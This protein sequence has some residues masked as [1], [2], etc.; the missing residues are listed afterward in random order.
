MAQ[1]SSIWGMNMLGDSPG[2]VGSDD[3]R[4]NG[5][6][7]PLARG[8]R[9]NA[10]FHLA[11]LEYGAL[12]R[13]RGELRAA[14]HLNKAQDLGADL[15][16]LGVHGDVARQGVEVINDRLIKLDE[17]IERV[18]RTLFQLHSDVGSEDKLRMERRWPI[19]QPRFEKHELQT[20][21]RLV[22]EG[23][24]SKELANLYRYELQYNFNAPRK[25]QF[26]RDELYGHASANAIESYIKFHMSLDRRVALDNLFAHRG[27]SIRRL[28]REARES[29]YTYS[30]IVNS[31]F[32]RDRRHMHEATG[33]ATR[34]IDQ[35]GGVESRS[36][37]LK[38]WNLG[39]GIQS[40]TAPLTRPFYRFDQAELVQKYA[41]LQQDPVRTEYI[42]SLYREGK[43][44]HY[45]LG[46]NTKDNERIEPPSSRWPQNGSQGIHHEV[47][48]RGR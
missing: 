1:K 33:F 11:E 27:D 30:L 31:C 47:P 2:S 46:L 3:N 43:L 18:G 19:T 29:L 40:L 39:R 24:R 35:G 15:S 16:L 36:V 5:E 6:L 25:E 13:H 42:Q 45:G 34:L 7:G 17:K 10:R 37:E 9:L 21:S 8:D 26:G 41:V 28:P 4:L 12:G 23:Q 22:Q 44:A 38:F 32:E 20:V 14:F 48:D